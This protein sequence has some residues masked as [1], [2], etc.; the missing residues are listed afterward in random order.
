M[1]AK[2]Q[3][4]FEQQ[5]QLLQAVVGVL[6]EPFNSHSAAAADAEGEDAAD[7][8]LYRPS[9]PAVG[10][11]GLQLACYVGHRVLR[12]W[13]D[14]TAAVALAAQTDASGGAGGNPVTEAVSLLKQ[15][16]QNWEFEL[17]Q[18][19]VWYSLERGLSHCLAPRDA[20]AAA[21]QQRAFVE[22]HVG[23]NGLMLPD[24]S[25]SD[26]A[27][28]RDAENGGKE[29][30]R[31]N[32]AGP[33]SFPLSEVLTADWVMLNLQHPA[34]NA[35]QLMVGA[36]A[37]YARYGLDAPVTAVETGEPLPPREQNPLDPAGLA[38]VGVSGEAVQAAGWARVPLAPPAAAA[39]AAARGLAWPRCSASLQ[40]CHPDS[41]TPPWGCSSCGR[42]YRH[43][44]C[45]TLLAG[46]A[47]QQQQQDSV[48]SVPLCLVCGLRLTPGGAAAAGIAGCSRLPQGVLDGSPAVAVGASLSD[49]VLD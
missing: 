45:R 22:Q 38:P 31:A 30:S 1:L 42:R 27:A 18:R 28:A 41:S 9:V 37:V 48:P 11:R 39:A 13:E 16:L 2:E 14:G 47:V 7:V 6:T 17:V 44:P 34:L 8:S 12:L 46:P 33:G 23:Q 32:A 4:L 21:A 15:Q 5:Q 35:G 10:W 36:A 49:I 3:R 19:H 25:V 24:L 20:A 26:A 40:L 29:A 43:V